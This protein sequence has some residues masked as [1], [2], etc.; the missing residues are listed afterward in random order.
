MSKIEL[1]IGYDSGQR[2]NKVDWIVLILGMIRC[3][4]LNS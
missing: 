3:K 2:S 4:G 1:M